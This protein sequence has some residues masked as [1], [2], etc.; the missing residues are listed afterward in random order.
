MA[1]AEIIGA[2]VGVMLL[3][4]VAYLLV[5]SVI[6]TAE[7]VSTAQKDLTLQN[8]ARMKTDFSIYEKRDDGFF[9]YFNI[10]NTGNEI[11]SDFDH[12]DLYSYYD[13]QDGYQRYKYDKYNIGTEAGNWSIMKFQD[14][15]VH[16]RQL[17]PGEKM[18]CMAVSSSNSNV[19]IELV[20][21]NGVFDSAIL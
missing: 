21:G 18:W 15:Y 10:T 6:T 9:I 5:G 17:D 14:D 7:V 1:V 16:P 20:S 2:A 13:G 4:V 3:V 11:I 12:M 8:E 19:W